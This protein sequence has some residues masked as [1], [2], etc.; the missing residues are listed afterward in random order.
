VAVAATGLVYAASAVVMG[1]GH[2]RAAVV[3]EG[4]ASVTAIVAL[5]IVWVVPDATPYA[6]GLAVT[7]IG[8]AALA[9]RAAAPYLDADWMRRGLWPAA[10]ATTA[11]SAAVLVTR[12]AVSL[13]AVP[14]LAVT[15]LAYSAVTALVLTLTARPLVLEVMR[16]QRALKWGSATVSQS[17]A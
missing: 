9:F 2:V 11:A 6:W 12:W 14:G 13:D 10:A 15:S 5:A 7:Q 4:T 1:M 3:A 17:R 8:A 16:T